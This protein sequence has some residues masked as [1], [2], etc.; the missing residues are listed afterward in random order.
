MRRR[1]FLR[2]LVT[3]VVGSHINVDQLLSNSEA[4][5]GLWKP[6]PAQLKFLNSPIPTALWGVPYHQ[7]NASSG[8]WLGIHR[9]LPVYE[10][11]GKLIKLLEED[12]KREP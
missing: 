5:S 1:N 10:E 2:L 12:K 4:L 11:I 8:Q 9:G 3:G 6:H 7:S